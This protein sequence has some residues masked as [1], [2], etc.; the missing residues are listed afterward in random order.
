M[1]GADAQLAQQSAARAQIYQSQP[2]ELY[3]STLLAIAS[4]TTAPSDEANE[5]LRKNISLLPIPVKQI[6]RQGSIN[7]LEFNA[8]G[9]LFATAGADGNAVDQEFAQLLRHKILRR[10]WG[11][12]APASASFRPGSGSRVRDPSVNSPETAPASSPRRGRAF[13]SKG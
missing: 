8:A 10:A 13:R 7:S 6:Q 12:R 4:W 11:R 5:I 2:G 3:T 1:R 9:N